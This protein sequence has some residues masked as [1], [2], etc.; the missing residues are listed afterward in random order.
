M[1]QYLE[2]EEL[3]VGSRAW[4]EHTNSFEKETTPAGISRHY[5]NPEPLS[6][7]DYIFYGQMFQATMYGRTIEA[8]RFRKND[9]RD[10]CQGALIWMYNDCWGEIGWTPIDY[11]LR[12]KPSYYWIRNANA[13]VK[14][15]VRRRGKHLVTRVVNDALKQMKVTVHYG[16]MRVDGSNLR[17]KSEAIRIDANG[18]VEIGKEAI[19][20]PKVLNPREWIYAAYL[21][22]EDTNQ[23]PSVWLLT[24]YREL[25]IPKP[26]IRVTVRGRNIQLISSTYC[27]GVHFRDNGKRVFS[28]NYFDLLPGVSKSITCLA[29]KVPGRVR[30][31]AVT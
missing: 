25:D 18:M 17:M 2:P 31:H 30:F 16:W 21:A 3:H 7:S 22:R 15:I 6:I 8:L 9:P 24:P 12:R 14:A 28:D 11:Y 27:H 13:P 10:D 23:S 5:T 1:K 29:P 4:K 20:S 26:D 19:A